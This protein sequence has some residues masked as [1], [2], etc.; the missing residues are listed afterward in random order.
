MIKTRIQLED[1]IQNI[2]IKMSDGNPGAINTLFEVIKNGEKIDPQS[3]FAGV[4]SIL[5]L[6][7]FGIYGSSIYVLYNDKCNK[8]IRKFIMLLRAVQLGFI[9]VDRLKEL[10][11]D[12]TRQI[13]LS[14]EEWK[15]IEMKVCETL[16]D[17]AKE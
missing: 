8:N 2:I 5:L 15:D 10:A 7:S 9:R 11:E 6:D 1:S 12:Q 14:D 3:A 4:G 17:F 16:E 13:N